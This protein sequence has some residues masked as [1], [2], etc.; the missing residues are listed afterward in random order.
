MLSLRRHLEDF[1]R[2]H[3]HWVHGWLDTCVRNFFTGYRLETLSNCRLSVLRVL[4]LLRD[5]RNLDDLLQ[6]LWFLHVDNLFNNSFGILGRVVPL[7][8]SEQLQ[9]SVSPCDSARALCVMICATSTIFSTIRSEARSSGITLTHARRPLLCVVNVDLLDLFLRFFIRR[10][11][12]HIFH[13]V[14]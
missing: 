5:F 13:H 2:L 1:G 12:T 6:H 7:A 3:L 11:F 8:R 9:Q 4:N 14:R 10:F